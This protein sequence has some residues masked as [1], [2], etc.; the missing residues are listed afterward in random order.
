MTDDTKARIVIATERGYSIRTGHPSP[1]SQVANQVRCATGYT[2]GISTLD[3]P[4][5]PLVNGNSSQ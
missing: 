2:L 4:R 5:V 3:G 1:A